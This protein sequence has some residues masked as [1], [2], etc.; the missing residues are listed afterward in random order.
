MSQHRQGDALSGLF[1]HLLST[2]QR[3]F[4]LGNRMFLLLPLAVIAQGRCT[5][6]ER[7]DGQDAFELNCFMC[8]R[9]ILVWAICLCLRAHLF[10]S[11]SVY[12][13]SLETDS[14]R[15]CMM[16]ASNTIH[17]E[18]KMQHLFLSY[19][20]PHKV[21]S[22]KFINLMFCVCRRHPFSFCITRDSCYCCDG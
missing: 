1:A 14:H 11:T 16:W 22:Q 7:N 12:I 6:W 18:K 10:I 9:N 20:F 2:A 15:C 21:K 17:S 3:A 19:S 8:F 4:L 13:E 5:Y